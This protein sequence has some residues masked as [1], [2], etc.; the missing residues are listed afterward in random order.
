MLLTLDLDLD[1]LDRVQDSARDLP[2][3]IIHILSDNSVCVE[4]RYITIID[5]EPG[6]A[7]WL[8]LL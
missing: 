1:Q 6:M 7:V 2:L 8:C 3:R 4:D 5:C